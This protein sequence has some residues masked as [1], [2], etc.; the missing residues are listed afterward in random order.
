MGASRLLGVGLVAAVVGCGGERDGAVAEA[1]AGGGG[2]A[3]TG[4]GLVGGSFS[5]AGSGQRGGSGGASAGAPVGGGAGEAVAP[6]ESGVRE[7]CRSETCSGSRLCSEG[8]WLE[9]ECGPAVGGAGGAVGSGGAPSEGGEGGAVD[10]AGAGGTAGEA[11]GGT[12]GHAGSAGSPVGGAGGAACECPAGYCGKLDGCPSFKWCGG[13][14]N[15]VCADQ[16]DGSKACESAL[17]GDH[18]CST[19]QGL[20]CCTGHC[21]RAFF[22]NACRPGEALNPVDGTECGTC[23]QDGVLHY[24]HAP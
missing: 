22:G 12:A 10:A 24:C 2:S 23:E 21:Y 13:C 19:V 15:D 9:C 14:G 18:L 3:G 8:S 17:S 6:C 11:T 4:A 5:E 1:Q 20:T 16:E 7:S